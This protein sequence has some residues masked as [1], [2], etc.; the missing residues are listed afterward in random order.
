VR[1][2][3]FKDVDVVLYA[4]VGSSLGTSWGDGG[5][6]GLVSVEYMFKGESSHAAAA[7]WAGKS[8]LD[9]LELMDVGWNFKRAHLRTQQRSHYVISNGGDQPNVVPA[10]ASVW[11]YYDPTRYKTYLE[12]LGVPYP[13][14]MPASSGVQ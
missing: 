5:G 12:Q 6:T 10:N 4:H 11:Y 14:P 8:A 13:P 2:G 9:A 7:P 3:L 1:A